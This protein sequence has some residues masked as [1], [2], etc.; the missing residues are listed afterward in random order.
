MDWSAP[1]YT[2]IRQLGTGGSGRVVLAV[3]D[4][5]GVK[6]A[7]K[8]LSEELRRD[9]AALTRFQ[10]E[11]RL[12]VSLQDPNIARMWEYVQEPRGAAIVMELVNGV[13]LRAL[14]REAGETGPEAALVVLKGSL[15]GL[16]RAHQ[17][18]LVHRDY[19]PENVIVRDDGV[20]KLVDFGIAV[21]QG[22]T[23][24]PEGTPPY[25]APELWEGGPATPS[26]DVYAAT[27]V[28][29]ECLTGHRPYQ[30]TEP[31]V[32]GYQHM[33]APIPAH[34]APEPVRELVMRGLAKN[35][36]DRP[37]GALT[38]LSELER[39]AAAGYGEDW[40]ERG[41]RRLIALV[42]LLPLLL[43][44]PAQAPTV[45]SGGT[46]LFRTV[47]HGARSNMSKLLVGVGA[48]A[49]AVVA[50][51]A[52]VALA[53]RDATP[54]KPVDVVAEAPT[55]TPPLSP[56]A[57]PPT[58]DT[59][60]PSLVENTDTG[61]PG[62]EPSSSTVVSQVSPSTTPTVVKPTPTVVKPTPTPK[63]TTKKPTPTP[64]ITTKKP[65]PTPTPTPTIT[66]K[67]VTSVS[68]LS[69]A[70]LKVSAAGVA[71]GAATISTTG[72]A[73]IT[74]TA[75]FA[76]AGDVVHTERVRLRG[77]R[78]YTSAFTHDLGDEACGRTV[79]LT[80]RTTPAAPGG[81]RTVRAA[82]P[83]C[84]TKVTALRV[85]L[86]VAE[87]PGRAVQAA[88]R[89]ATS[90]TAAVELDGAF[91][92]NGDQVATRSATLSGRRS[93]SRTLS[94]T[95]DKRPCGAVLSVT[96]RAGGESASART[97]VSCPAGV[98]T[99]SIARASLNARGLAAATVVVLTNGEQPVQLHVSFRLGEA[100][101]NE[102]VELTGQTSYTRTVS[103][104]FEKVPCGSEWAIS[105]STTPAA[106][107]GGDSTGGK[108]PACESQDT[109]PTP[110][111]SSD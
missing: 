43:P 59:P 50:V 62:E 57:L 9:P 16:S 44:M 21:R 36:A 7:I 88:V 63:V 45:S 72:T 87:A 41:R 14:L 108:T 97:T 17:V 35:P 19:K 55:T 96:V 3:H 84:A 106:D 31:V 8:Y 39:V 85:S 104:T 42:G 15:L 93:Y 26:T 24:H 4:E 60:T 49:V 75:T 68:A 71:S 1:G 100:T 38:F 12:L 109:T 52:T 34:D 76:V 10:T 77:S 32:L 51:V 98:R 95:F 27:A 48:T 99:V 90:G 47:L 80:V 105:A 110:D 82:V 22:T 6:V 11:A 66:P 2:E 70:A 86:D 101:H 79:T 103:F 73:Q 111:H 5:T 30:S 23:A 53:G 54:I 69:L 18:G 61:G 64:T 40:E 33:H 20:S 29:F 83:A 65:T 107:G 46:T 67:P 81:A 102:E 74:V 92:V 58:A 28:F 78:T 13:S 56:L 91:S 37:P 25:M 89:V 94:Y